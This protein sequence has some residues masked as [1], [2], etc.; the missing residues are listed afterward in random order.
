[1][2][3]TVKKGRFGLDVII[4]HDYSGEQLEKIHSY[5]EKSAEFLLPFVNEEISVLD[6]GA[7]DGYLVK[8]LPTKNSVS[9]DLYPMSEEVIEMDFYEMAE[10]LR[11]KFDMV[12]INHTLEHAD[13]PYKLMEQVAKVTEKK[14]KLFISVPEANSPWAYELF[15]S[16]THYAC[17]TTE[18]LKTMVS[19]FGYTIH[20]VKEKEFRSGYKELWLLAEKI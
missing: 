19:R 11:R 15:E 18:F 20:C 8:K 7:G 13:S 9:I 17:F 5:V 1:M 10:K 6:V 4:R 12:I 3:N 14:G 16:T 2:E